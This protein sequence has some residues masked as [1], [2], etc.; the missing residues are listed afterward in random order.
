MFAVETSSVIFMKR[1]FWILGTR[2]ASKELYTDYHIPEIWGVQVFLWRIAVSAFKLYYPVKNIYR[3]L[4]FI[5]DLKKDFTKVL[6]P[7]V[8]EDFRSASILHSPWDSVL[9]AAEHRSLKSCDVP[10]GQP[11][12][13]YPELY[14][15]IIFITI[16]INYVIL[17]N[18]VGK[19][20]ANISRK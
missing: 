17:R 16:Y 9:L 19:M 10:S 20:E 2:I 11:F 4:Y 3:K 13:T 8:R 7:V 5:W 12:T 14:V 1:L 6:T 15:Y 18:F